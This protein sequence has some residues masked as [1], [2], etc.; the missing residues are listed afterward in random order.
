MKASRSPER[1]AQIRHLFDQ[2]VDLSP[3]D[4]AALLDQ[5][6]EDDP[7]LRRAVEALLHADLHVDDRLQKLDAP[8][9][10]AHEN[11]AANTD[12]FTG[13][14]ISH[15]EVA[16]KL[17]GGGMGVVYK[18][19]DLKLDRTVALKFLPLHLTT[20]EK[21]KRRFIHEAK[22]AS[23][24]DHANIC[25]VY[26]I[27]ET[28]EGHSLIA[29]AYVKGETLKA[30]IKRGPL[31]LG[32]ALDYAIQVATGLAKAHAEGIVH[33][34]VKP[35]NVMVNEEGVV[36]IVDFGLAKLVGG[37]QLT[38]TGTTLGTVAY[39]SPEQARGESVDHR[40]D[41]WSL[42]VI[43][44]EMIAGRLPFAGDYERAMIYAILNEE[45]GPL[46]GLRT[47]VPMALEGI[48]SKCLSKDPSDR[49]QHVDEVPVDLR[50]V[51]RTATG[52]STAI[53][54]A[55]PVTPSRRALPWRIVAPLVMALIL[56]AGVIGWILKPAPAQPVT[57]SSIPLPA[58]ERI[59][60]LEHP[61]A[62]SP[63][64]SLLVYA[65][66]SEATAQSRLYLRPMD[67]FEATPIPGSEGAN[68]LFFSPDGQW[69]GFHAGD[70]LKK[71]SLE[72]G[73]IFTICTVPLGI[74]GAS[75]GEDDTI[76]FGT[77]GRSGLR[78]VSASGGSPE[79]LTEPDTLRGEGT[80]VMPQVLPGSR[81]VLFSMAMSSSTSADDYQIA[82]LDLET[83]AWKHLS[84]QGV[85][86]RYAPTGHLIYGRTEGLMA[87]AFDLDQLR[88]V[89]APVPVLPGVRISGWETADYAY[90]RTGTL[91]Y[92]PG[93]ETATDGTLVRVNR[94]GEAE[95]LVPERR[96]YKF[97]RLS[98]DGNQLAVIVEDEEGRHGLWFIDLGRGGVFDRRALNTTFPVWTRDGQR[99]AFYSYETDLPSLVWMWA[100]G[101]GEAEHLRSGKSW[102]G[103]V[104]FSSDDR[105]LTF[106]AFHPER[107]GD[108]WIVDMEE[109]TASPFLV[110]E[111]NEGVP[112]FSP[113]GRWIAYMSDAS[114]QNE[115]YVKPYPD[116]TGA[117]YQV[118]TDGGA[119]PVWSRDGRELYYRKGSAML[120]V[121]VE[122][123]GGFTREVPRLV[124]EGPY[125]GGVI[126]GFLNYDVDADG[127]FVMVRRNMESLPQQIHVVENWFEELKGL[128]PTDE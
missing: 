52:R 128:V 109:R 69:V 78:R 48:V 87:V 54:G 25:T 30:K 117:T 114:G 106:Y 79:V 7:D 121:E 61:V 14:T 6:C 47:G 5:I 65:A 90:S 53:T 81:A 44:Y 101:R 62:L 21:A 68:N 95:P 118:S 34:D 97:P 45:P 100:D 125:V 84:E 56:I 31:P 51:D 94:A 91:A 36:K 96:D 15:Y 108:I 35:A 19:R 28:D 64:G 37:T 71:Y 116:T 98:P 32:Q 43:L 13:Q 23:A 17:G 86:P 111:T 113:D 82:V 20:D 11:R 63:D 41:I 58:S 55:Q 120:A 33:R 104:S 126:A 92:V 85:G 12:R 72:S 105:L 102:S 22:A 115:V 29:M 70:A 74:V 27:E 10:T 50:A 26:D 4:R 8:T 88:T 83:G 73:S 40:T 18:A 3:A 112:M 77:R 80:H 123:E 75:W 99:L 38:Q 57:R 110:T 59:H 76:I 49:Y 66:V 42:G 89:D 107:Q 60:W 127:R 67:S 119:E 122:T 39:M 16:E 1:A 24:L 9:H 93:G 103:P 46:T 2:V 124:F